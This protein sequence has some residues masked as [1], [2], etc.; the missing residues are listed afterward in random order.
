MHNSSEGYAL[1]LSFYRPYNNFAQQPW[2]CVRRAS[3]PPPLRIRLRNFILIF[4]NIIFLLWLTHLSKGECTVC[5]SLTA[6]CKCES[7]LR[8]MSEPESANDVTTNGIA[9]TIV[10]MSQALDQC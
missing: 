9:N 2:S 6:C 8:N 1:S 5:T 3:A 10:V 7:A 4:I